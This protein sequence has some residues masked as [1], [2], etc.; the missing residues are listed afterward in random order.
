MRAVK[1]A[2]AL[3]RPDLPHLD[4]AVL[5]AC[6]CEERADS[7]GLHICG[8]KAN[9]AGCDFGPTACR[10]AGVAKAS[11]AGGPPTQH[12]QPCNH[13]THAPFADAKAHPPD[14]SS[15]ESLEK[16]RLSTASS[17]IMNIS[18]AWYCRSFFSRPVLASH[19]C[20]QYNARTQSGE[21]QVGPRS[22]PVLW[23]LRSANSHS[24]WLNQTDSLRPHYGF[25]T[26]H[27]DE[28]VHRASG[29]Q[30]TI[31]REARHLGVALGRKPAESTREGGQMS[32]AHLGQHKCCAARSRACTALG[33]GVAHLTCYMCAVCTQRVC[34]SM[35]AG[36]QTFFRHPLDFVLLDG[37][38]RLHLIPLA[39]GLAP[40]QV[41]RHAGGQQALRLLPAVRAQS[42]VSTSCRSGKG[43]SW[44]HS[45]KAAL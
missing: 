31:G 42:R 44:P 45:V 13:G 2:Q 9:L 3:A 10:L 34:R 5:G 15:S 28:A 19:T 22:I 8:F 23:W 12:Q 21:L 1:L 6:G 37:G 4:A 39:R 7:W 18:S 33:P 38:R 26:T 24:I 27:L 20:V 30:G 40:E 17:C 35:H 16:P 11:A 41:K 36:A 14:T 25:A 29:Q 43:K 32:V